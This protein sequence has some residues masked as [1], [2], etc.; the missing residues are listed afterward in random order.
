[1]D[2]HPGGEAHTRYL[3]SLSKLPP[4]SRWLDFGAGDG[5]A[6]RIL[7]RLGFEALGLDLSPRGQGVAEGNFLHTG[8]ER[9]AFDGILSQCAITLSGNPTKAFQEAYRLLRTGGKL[10][11]S[12]V[13]FDVPQMLDE[14]KNT[15]FS[16][17]H[18]EDLTDQWKAYYLEALWKEESV[19]R[20]PKGRH[21]RYVLLVCERM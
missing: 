13:C 10:V 20:L 8:L 15:G 11:F 5:G 18:L 7:R 16:V 1:M 4:G 9:S 19:P 12:D 2:R 21:C 6:V 14:L 17:L 3:I